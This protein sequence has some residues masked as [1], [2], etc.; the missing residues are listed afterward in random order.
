MALLLMISDYFLFFLNYYYF[1]ILFATCKCVDDEGGRSTKKVKVFK[2][3]F[4]CIYIN[5]N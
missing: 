5:N 3:L 2:L 4:V 1:V